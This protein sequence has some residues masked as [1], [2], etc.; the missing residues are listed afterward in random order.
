M[1]QLG[2]RKRLDAITDDDVS[3]LVAERRRDVRRCGRD[4]DGRQLFRPITAR[5][6]NKTTVSLLRRVLR[7]ARDNWNA[8]ILREPVWKKHFLPE[9]RRPIRE[10]T[11]AEEVRL[12]AVEDADFAALREFAIISGLRRRALLLTWPQVDFE[13]AELRYQA[14]GGAWKILPLSKRGYQILWSRCGHHPE[15]VFTYV[16]RKSRTIPKGKQVR[17]KG[18]RYPVTYSGMGSHHD[19]I[20]KKA[21]VDARIHDMRHTTGSRT[22]RRTGNLKVTSML[23]G[24]SDIAITA[25]FY[26][27]VMVDD[28]RQAMESTARAENPEVVPEARRPRRPKP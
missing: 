2:P 18:R 19:S 22:L 15:W 8:A 28:I 24:H 13:N 7:R 27:H 5:T 6:V 1:A 21:G 11:V 20:W 25:R 3:K 23:L 26:T 14:K 16:C 17:I 10:I 9:T 12:N 4:H